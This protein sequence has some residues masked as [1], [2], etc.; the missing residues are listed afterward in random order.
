MEWFNQI[1]ERVW[2]HNMSKQMLDSLPALVQDQLT[3]LG[4]AVQA[5]PRLESPRSQKFNRM[6][7]NVLS[8]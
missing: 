5:R 4:E 2:V 3:N 7:R 8:T 6:K 1:L